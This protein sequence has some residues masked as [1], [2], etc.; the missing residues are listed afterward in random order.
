MLQQ[1]KFKD[2][3]ALFPASVIETAERTIKKKRKGQSINMIQIL[4]WI[5][6]QYAF[7]KISQ[8]A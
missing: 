7:Y 3:L 1:P 6:K 4:E 5:E 2:Y 8:E